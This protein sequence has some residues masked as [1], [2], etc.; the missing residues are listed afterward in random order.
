M[1]CDT[2]I[3]VP[4]DWSLADELTDEQ[5]EQDLIELTYRLHRD[6][7]QPDLVCTTR[8]K[9]IGVRPTAYSPVEVE[10][11]NGDAD[12]DEEPE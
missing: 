1:G 11:V 3:D 7:A 5:I 2:P 10:I 9:L 12:G 4:D 8:E 6:D